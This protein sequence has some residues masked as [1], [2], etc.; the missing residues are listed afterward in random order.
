MQPQELHMASTN[1]LLFC[2]PHRPLRGF[3]NLWLHRGCALDSEF[4]WLQCW[5]VHTTHPTPKLKVKGYFEV[6]YC[7]S[8]EG[9]RGSMGN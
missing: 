8:K 5:V 7:E 6:V 1:H 2:G 9:L 4:T 3:H